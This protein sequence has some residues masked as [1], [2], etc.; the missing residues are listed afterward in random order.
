M[1]DGLNLIAVFSMLFRIIGNKIKKSR[2]KGILRK[3]EINPDYRLETID[4]M[5]FT[6][7]KSVN[8]NYE[9]IF[10]NY[11][12]K[13]SNII[14]E[15]FEVKGVFDIDLERFLVVVLCNDFDVAIGHNGMN[16]LSKYIRIYYFLIKK[17][18]MNSKVEVCTYTVEDLGQKNLLYDFYSTI[19]EKIK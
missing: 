8:P 5:Y 2:L 11:K 17:D 1:R 14:T 4:E 10:K 16:Q 3:L 18:K 6:V 13:I 7:G 12:S 9:Y 19:Q 15:K